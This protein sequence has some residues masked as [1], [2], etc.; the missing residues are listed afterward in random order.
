MTW[1]LIWIHSMGNHGAAGG[2]L[3]TAGVLVVLVFYNSNHSG[4]GHSQWEE[5]LLCN[6]FSHWLSPYPEWSLYNGNYQ[7]DKMTSS[8]S[9]GSQMSYSVSLVPI[10]FDDALGMSI[11]GSVHRGQDNMSHIVQTPFSNTFGP[12]WAGYIAICV[13]FRALFDKGTSVS[14]CHLSWNVMT[15]WRTL[16]SIRALVVPAMLT[17]SKISVSCVCWGAKN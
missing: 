8:Y 12:Q 3:R 16:L 4:Y 7:A 5:A 17:I 1:D 11:L 13:Y 14:A 10:K 15:F 9:I 6:T 2:I